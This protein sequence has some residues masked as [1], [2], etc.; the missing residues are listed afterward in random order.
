[1][2][3]KNKGEKMSQEMM[4]QMSSEFNEIYQDLLGL[5]DEFTEGKV[6]AVFVYGSYEEQ[7]VSFNAFYEMDE[8]L[9]LLSELADLGLDLAFDRANQYYQLGAS[10]MLRLSEVFQKYGQEIPTQVKM[11]Y[12]FKTQE[13]SLNYDYELHFSNVKTLSSNDIFKEW[14]QEEKAK[15]GQ[16][17]SKI[18]PLLP[19]E[20]SESKIKGKE[21][22]LGEIEDRSK[23]KLSWLNKLFRKES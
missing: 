23:K 19:Q 16:F 22:K 9:Y 5:V 18:E 1:M 4:E 11:Y 10:D 6:D 21:P 15:R 20:N 2:I 7:V 17:S 8:G 13:F 12:S 14:F 3:L